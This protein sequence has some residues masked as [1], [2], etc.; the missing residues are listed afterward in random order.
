MNADWSKSL[1]RR[2]RDLAGLAYERDL[3]AELKQLD[4]DF[5]LWRAGEINAFELSDIIH[6]F[7]D[8]PARQ[9]YKQYVMGKAPD[10]DVADALERSVISEEEAGPE[11]TAALR[12]KREAMRGD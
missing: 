1:K 9:L 6:K 11:V 5:A 2:I 12:P 4:S 10:W 3:G 8:G 7:H